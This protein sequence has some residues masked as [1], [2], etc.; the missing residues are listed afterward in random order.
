MTEV[1][2]RA[3]NQSTEAAAEAIAAF[4][5]V[6]QAGEESSR[7]WM[8]LSAVNLLAAE[9]EN[10]IEVSRILYLHIFGY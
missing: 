1:R 3:S 9:G 2:R 10:M 5:Q 7:G 4:M 8:L 6:D